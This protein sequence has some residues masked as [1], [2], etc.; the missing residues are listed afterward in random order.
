[1]PTRTPRKGFGGAAFTGG[2]AAGNLMP[3]DLAAAAGT[4]SNFGKVG[5]TGTHLSSL[6]ITPCLSSQS[7]SG[8]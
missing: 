8:C 2:V 4:P 6:S 5:D 7:S 3:G 1:V